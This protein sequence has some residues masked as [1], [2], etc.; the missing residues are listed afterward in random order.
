MNQDQRSVILTIRQYENSVN[1]PACERVTYLDPQRGVHL[2]EGDELAESFRYTHLASRCAEYLRFG[3]EVDDVTYGLFPRTSAVKMCDSPQL[4]IEAGLRP[5]PMLFTQ[6]HL[7]DAIRPRDY[8]HSHRHGLT[9]EQVK[10]IPERLAEPVMLCDS[11]SRDDVML[12]VLCDVDSEGRPLIAA[13]KPGG[14]GYYERHETETNFILAVYGR[15][16]FQWYFDNL[17][18]PDRVIYFNTERG[19]ELDALAKLQLLRSHVVEPGLNNKIIRRPQCLVKTQI[20]GHE[21]YGLA[22]EARTARAASDALGKGG[23]SERVQDRKE[24]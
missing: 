6:R 4:Y 13:I 9:I 1:M 8:Y 12:A 23:T 20:A 15:E 14:Q 19:R 5:L 3:E 17:I 10:R 2:K 18:T 7:L 16:D 24:R 21:A 22:S 11:P